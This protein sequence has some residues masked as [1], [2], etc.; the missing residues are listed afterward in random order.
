[1]RCYILCY[2]KLMVQ[3]AV[4]PFFQVRYQDMLDCTSEP[5]IYVFNHR[6]ASDPFLM[7]VFGLPMIQEVNGWPMRIPIYG[8]AARTADY[9]DITKTAPEQMQAKIAELLAH[10]VS[11]VSFPEGHRSGSREL[12]SFHSGIF[13]IARAIHAPLYLCAIAGNETLPD[14]SFRFRNSGRI[15]IR[16]FRKISGNETDAFANDFA[17]KNF[18]F[19]LIKE[20]TANLDNLLDHEIRV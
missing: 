14:R 8:F 12:A 18:V 9:I 1:M 10:G 3:V 11:I 16:R 2:G 19:Q 15:I 6:S 13:R 7:S 5:G 20:E 17:L 4:R